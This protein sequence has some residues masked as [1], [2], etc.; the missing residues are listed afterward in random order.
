M[1]YSIEA[2]CCC[3]N[4]KRRAN[5]EDNFFFN[6]TCLQ[7]EHDGLEKTIYMNSPVNWGLMFAVFD[8]MGGENFGE[9]ASYSAAKCLKKKEGNY[10]FL[11]E[12]KH[13]ISLC[14]RANEEVYLAAQ[15]QGTEHMGTTMASL[16]FTPRNGYACN[17]G[18]SRAYRLRNG[19]L[20]QISL[21][22]VDRRP[23]MNTKKAPLSQYLGMDPNEI[24][25]EPYIAKKKLRRGD[26]FLLCSDG[27]TDMVSNREIRDILLYN[28]ADV[29]DCAEAL[30]KAALENGGRDNITTIICKIV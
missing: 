21:D 13:L 23:N 3:N 14:K 16:L 28:Q 24:I 12:E 29:I 27:L 5:N 20:L 26:I 8:G 11:S 10:F 9:V 22:H 6:S 30:T 1:Y 19:E 25:I 4:G 7:L 17:I 2:A 18:D 15:A